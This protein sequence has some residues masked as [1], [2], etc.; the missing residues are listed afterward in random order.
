MIR[1]LVIHVKEHA[2]R[3]AHI[4]EQIAKHYIPSAE[5]VDA[6]RNDHKPIEACMQSHRKA[7]QRVIELNEPCLIVED[8]AVF[9]DSF[10]NHLQN[11]LQ[12]LTSDADVALVGYHLPQ[13]YPMNNVIQH[14]RF[15]HANTPVLFAGAYGYIVNG[16]AAAN[17]LLQ[18]SA[19]IPQHPDLMMCDLSNAGQLKVFFMNQPLI[20]HG[21][22]PSTLNHFAAPKTA[23][24]KTKGK[25]QPPSAKKEGPATLSALDTKVENQYTGPL[26]AEEPVIEVAPVI[27]PVITPEILNVPKDIQK[28]SLIH[29]SRGRANMALKTFQ[30]WFEKSSGEIELEHVICVDSTDPQLKEYR[31]LF[32]ATS[33]KLIVADTD[34]CVAAT[35][36][37]AKAATGDILFYLAEDFRCPQNWDLLLANK[38]T[39]IKKPLC[40]K[41]ND[42]LTEFTAGI[43]T[44]PAINKLLYKKL[45][46]MWHPAYRSMF[47]DEDLYH[48]VKNNGWLAEA[49]ELKFTHEHQKQ[50]T[51]ETYKHT[52]ANWETGKKVFEERKAKNFPL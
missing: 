50:G 8:D 34:N 48:T 35:N 38:F 7:W 27:Q 11:R 32:A 16:A 49:P 45:G 26:P 1:T 42:G 19:N 18:Y 12:T 21:S 25:T 36:T 51:D 24:A 3:G 14:W 28:I 17:K 31:K 30:E 46:Y 23:D 40:V 13:L 47:V 15:P 41:V 5:Y 6:I 4:A 44:H 33:S 20:K 9:H 29:P 37:A 43:I 2:Q 10:V 22:M 39:G 52:N